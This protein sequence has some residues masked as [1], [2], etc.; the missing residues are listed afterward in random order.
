MKK[1]DLFG[2]AFI[3]LPDY[4]TSFLDGDC[5]VIHEHGDDDRTLRGKLLS[6]STGGSKEGNLPLII[7]RDVANKDNPQINK[8]GDNKYCHRDED[9]QPE[10]GTSIH[11][12]RWCVAA[13][14][15]QDEVVLAIFTLTFPES[16]RDDLETIQIVAM[17]DEAINSCEFI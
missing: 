9:N 5:C 15:N 11:G 13:M 10:G 17:L 7:L 1:I 6:V 14:S 16:L 12:I 8:I 4:W 2:R 3:L